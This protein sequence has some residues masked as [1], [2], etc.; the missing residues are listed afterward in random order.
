MTDP[1]TWPRQH[2]VYDGTW[3]GL[4]S[5]VFT[6]FRQRCHALSIVRDRAAITDLFSPV[7]VV[8][9]DPEHAQRVFKRLHQ[10]IGTQ[11]MRHLWVTSLAERADVD[12][13]LV[14][15]LMLCTTGE[16]GVWTDPRRPAVLAMEQWRKRVQH[17]KHRME[18]FVR[19]QANTNGIWTATIAPAYNVLPLIA[20][21]FRKR[22]ADM[23]WVIADQQRHYGLFFDGKAVH[24]VD[25]LHGADDA[26]PAVAVA[27]GAD[28]AAYRMLWRTYFEHV[29]IPERRNLKLQ[30]RHM[31]KRHW[32]LMLEMQAELP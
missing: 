5:V 9:T 4:L 13:L 3:A 17:E 12:M 24:V 32:K 15:Y 25:F 21:H 6:V 11:R 10:R 8:T 16:A 7:H 26:L 1:G 28:E 20:P 19:F 18:A 27:A 22:Y 23:H 29:D 31:P 2:Y 14:E 30:M